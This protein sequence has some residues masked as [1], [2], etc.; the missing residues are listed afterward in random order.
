[1]NSTKFYQQILKT[2]FLTWWGYSRLCLIADR[3]PQWRPATFSRNL[4]LNLFNVRFCDHAWVCRNVIFAT[5][6]WPKWV[7]W[8]WAKSLF[9]K[10]WNIGNAKPRCKNWWRWLWFYFHYLVLLSM[11]AIGLVTE[12]NAKPC[13]CS[14]M[15]LSNQTYMW[16]NFKPMLKG[17]Y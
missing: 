6:E 10:K 8:D 13:C 9:A 7:Y 11:L 1:M 3:E 12:I 15:I 2:N 5:H 17:L 14:I 16:R 4:Y